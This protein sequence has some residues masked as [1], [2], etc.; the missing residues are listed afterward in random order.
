MSDQNVLLVDV[1]VGAR[2]YDSGPLYS[3]R[4]S[5]IFND[6]SLY[7]M[8]ENAMDH[9]GICQFEGMT[10]DVPFD[11]KATPCSKVPVSVAE[12]IKQLVV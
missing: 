11:S 12:R 4:F 8:S 2:V 1:P 6:G 7:T 5:V 3:D 10:D 9:Y